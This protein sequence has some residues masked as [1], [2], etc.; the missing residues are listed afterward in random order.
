MKKQ[1]LTSKDKELIEKA[2]SVPRRQKVPGGIIGEVGC[3]L[4]T[5][6]GNIFVGVSLHL[7]CGIGFCAEHSAIANMVSHSNETEIKTI[8]A[9]WTKGKKWGVFIPCGRCRELMQQINKR[10][11]NTWVIISTKEKSKI[12]GAPS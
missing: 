6:K 1:K 3:A 5:A 9:V 11:R 12:K 4:I 10:N 2:R 7:C 8:V